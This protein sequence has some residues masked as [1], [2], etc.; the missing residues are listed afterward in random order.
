MA[1]FR[2]AQTIATDDWLFQQQLRAEME[3]EAWRRLREVIATPVQPVAL[4]PPAPEQRNDD[5]EIERGGSIILKA[6]VRFALGA[7]GAYLG[8]LAAVDGGLGEFEIWL[9]TGSGFLVA[10]SLSML[11]PARRFVHILSEV[12]RIALIAFVAYGA[13]W[14]LL[15]MPVG[16]T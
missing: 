14:V 8:W 9:A 16:P 4:A 11:D 7:F 12:M 6:I 1:G 3:A 13:L 10:L 5:R 15:H 2:R